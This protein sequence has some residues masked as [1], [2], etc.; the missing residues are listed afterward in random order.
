[1]PQSLPDLATLAIADLYPELSAT[2]LPRRLFELAR[3]EDLAVAGD[4]TTRACIS[5]DATLA[6]NLVAREDATLAGL[7]CIDELIDAFAAEITAN[8]SPFVDGDRVTKGDVILGLH[9]NARGLLALERTLLNTIGRLSGIAMLTALYKR[10]MLSALPD[11]APAPVLV[12]TRKTTP[13]W[14]VLEKYAVRCG[15]GAAHRLGLHDAM[16]IKDNHL[17]NVALD[18]FASFV[19]DAATKA[20]HATPLRFVMV[21]VDTLDQFRELFTLESGIIDM[22]LL[23]NMTPGLLRE[24]VTLRNT[25]APTLTLEASGGVNLSSIGAIA[26]TGVDRI[27]VGALTHQ[28]TSVDFALDADLAHS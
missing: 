13:G 14:R 17:A 27:A 2:G 12:D 8:P 24:A 3:D 5:E 16:L 15:G 28:A 22:V 1:M 10:T 9:G 23:D 4:V 18:D 26:S 7:A 19:R 11:G 6:V 20:R 25:T 21:E